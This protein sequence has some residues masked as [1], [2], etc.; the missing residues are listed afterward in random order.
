LQLLA[1]TRHITAET[2]LGGQKLLH[3][4]LSAT[5]FDCFARRV[6]LLWQQAP[7]AAVEEICCN[8]GLQQA[9]LL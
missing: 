6:L 4:S 3:A 5:I 1:S 9:T 2:P 7:Q 8:I